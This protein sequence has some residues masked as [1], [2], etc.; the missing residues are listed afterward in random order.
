M[1]YNLPRL[2]LQSSCVKVSFCRYKFAI[3]AKKP[4]T[5]QKKSLCLGAV[6]HCLTLASNVLFLYV[7][8]QAII[9]LM[10]SLQPCIHYTRMCILYPHI[11]WC[12]CAACY[13]GMKYNIQT[14]SLS[15]HCNITAL[16]VRLH[17]DPLSTAD[18]LINTSYRLIFCFLP[19]K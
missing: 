11:S 5:K 14:I 17:S 6:R 3:L 8:A 15:K 7:L 16:L 9:Q 12:L 4:Q 18:I 19:I 2:H 10:V 13:L 1:S